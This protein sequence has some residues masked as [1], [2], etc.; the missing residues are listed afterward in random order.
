MGKVD[1]GQLVIKA[2]QKEG[3]KYIFSLSGGH[4]LRIYAASV[5]TEIKIIDTRHEQ[6]A[7]HMA[8]GWSL[9]TGEMGVCA[10]TAGPGL[11]DA[12]TAVAN[13]YLSNS[14]MLIFGGRSALFENDIG[15][16]QDLDQ[17][18]LMQPIT[19]WAKVCYETKRIPE[20]ISMAYRHAL[21]GRPGPVYL[22]IPFDILSQEVEEAD[23]AFP[24][25]YRTP[26]RPAGNLQ[27]IK[28]A[29][30]ILAK[31]EKPLI[32]SGS[33]GFWSQA[34]EA[35]TAFAEKADIPVI[36][37]TYGRGILPDSHRLAITGGTIELL[38][39]GV[40]QADAI[41]LL[42]SRLNFS[43]L[44]GRVIPPNVKIIQVD[45]EGSELGFNRGPDVGIHGDIKLVLE[46]LTEQVPATSD[47]A[48]AR[49][50]KQIVQSST[51]MTQAAINMEAVPIH[52][53]R[54]VNDIRDVVGPEGIY[55][56]DGGDIHIFGFETFP[57]ERPGSILTTSQQFG[58][59]GVGLPYAIA[60][61]L[62]NPDRTVILLS[63]DGTFGLNGMEF[64]TALRHGLPI[65]CIV[66]NDQAWGMIKHGMEIQF[67]NDKVCGCDLGPVRYDLMVE[68]LGGHGEFVERPEDIKPALER[69]L[70]SG[71]PACINVLTDPTLSHPST[72]MAAEMLGP[73]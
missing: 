16:L 46:Q 27:A 9:S 59:L 10:V 24:E 68:G 30:E 6:A 73:Y 5:G 61:K 41:L 33:G 12:V 34:G 70:K 66:G 37:R 36:T 1:G 40:T 44:Y 21:S 25:K 42:G 15:S 52:P 7:G 18:A 47:R 72:K 26:Y 31:A 32:L 28:A 19:K 45:I 49:E 65:V 58:C 60:A 53:Q 29:A 57:A 2:L 35:L 23:V 39:T 48:W 13:A 56:C 71:K 4:I 62:A 17:M 20:Y 22:E 54:L 51:E 43:L 38:M 14:P 55:I 69:A 3:V 67:G 63:G 11:T 50:I 8:E 64:D